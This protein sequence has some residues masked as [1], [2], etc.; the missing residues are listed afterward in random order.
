MSLLA[1]LPRRAPPARTA[2]RSG[3]RFTTPPRR[4]A[5]RSPELRALLVGI[6]PPACAAPGSAAPC[7]TS[8]RPFTARD[9]A[10]DLDVAA[11]LDLPDATADTLFLGAQEALRNVAQHAAPHKSRSASTSPTAE[12]RSTVRDDGAGFAPPSARA[13]ADTTSGSSLLADLAAERGGR[14]DVSSA[15]AQGTRLNARGPG[16]VIR[17]LAVD[18]HPVVRAGLAQLLAQADDIELIGWPRTQSARWRSCASRRPTSSS[19]ISRCR[20]WTGSRRRAHSPRT[21][22]H[23]TG[24]PDLVLGLRADPRR[25]RRRRHRLP[26]QGRGPRRAAPGHPHGGQGRVATR[27]QGGQRAPRRARGPPPR[28]GPHAARARSPPDGRPGPAEQA[29]R[30]PPR[31][32]RANRQGSPHPHLR[33]HRRHR[34]NPGGPVGQAPP[35]TLT[36]L[37][38]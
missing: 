30:P 26:A 11:D 9:I 27:P 5:A 12:R 15:P 24:R 2:H 13:P 32:Q 23:P 35:P 7:R 6:Y 8:S 21:S 29:D 19:W 3:G 38:A 31:D 16:H 10:V 36:H 28:R 14:L 17:V 25:A 34:P 1:R 22:S 20:A 37:D 33:A 18:D 4:P